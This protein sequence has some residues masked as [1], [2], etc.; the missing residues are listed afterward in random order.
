[1]LTYLMQSPG[2]YCTRLSSV[3]LGDF[4]P[5]LAKLRLFVVVFSKKKSV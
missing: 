3:V 4:A 1:M 2:P 5:T